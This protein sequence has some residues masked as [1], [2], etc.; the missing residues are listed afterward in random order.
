MGSGFAAPLDYWDLERP[1]VVAHDIEGAATLR[2]HLL[3]H[4]PMAAL[5]LLDVVAL[6]P[7]GWP[8]CRL[9]RTH[10][11]VF[12]QLAHAIHEASCAPMWEPPR[13]DRSIATSRPTHLALLGA[14]CWWAFYRQMAHGDQRDS[15]EVKPG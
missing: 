8:F 7:W 9:V 4:R 3:H 12:E 15:D 13:L 2:A 14:A 11:S 6:A 5:A 10:D 1:G